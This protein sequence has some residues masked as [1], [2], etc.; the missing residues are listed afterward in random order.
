MIVTENYIKLKHPG[1]VDLNNSLYPLLLEWSKTKEDYRLKQKNSLDHSEWLDRHQYFP[2]EHSWHS[3]DD[4]Y[5]YE[6]FYPLCYFVT[7]LMRGILNQEFKF[8]SMW[9]KV[10]E[11]N[12][13]GKRHSHRGIISGVYYVNN[14][15]DDGDE[16]TGKINFYTSSGVKSFE[17]Q[18]G[19]II[20]FPAQTHHA[21][22]PY[23]GTNPRIN[24][25]WNMTI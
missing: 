10:A 20:I 16:I 1:H 13:Y 6:I 3:D 5:Q 17:P 8:S 25:S 9:A 11:K 14:G 21:V 12:S 15:F 7:G 22:D 4:L 2:I 19:D 24:I 18:D 23:L